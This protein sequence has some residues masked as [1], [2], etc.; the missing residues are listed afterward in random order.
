MS[1]PAQLWQPRGQDAL[2]LLC[3]HSCLIAPGHRGQCGVRENIH[4]RLVTLTYD[5]I[6]ALNLD[7]IEKKPLFHFLPGTTTLSL[8][9]PGCNLGCSFCQ[10]ASLSQPPR[11]GMAVRGEPVH[12]NRLVRMAQEAGAASIAYTYS[13][14]TIFYEL[15]LETARAACTAGLANVMVSNGFQSPQCLATL[16][17]FI[18]AANIDLKSFSDSFYHDICQARLAPVLRNLVKMKDMGWH[19]EVTTLVIPGLN[20]SER[21]LTDMARF[22]AAELGVDTPWHVSRFHPCHQM[23]DY[24]PTPLDTLR[25]AYDLGR[26][27][28]L[29]YVFVGNVPGSGLENTV[30]PGCGRTVVERRGFAVERMRLADGCCRDCGRK[31]MQSRSTGDC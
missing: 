19:L 17:P 1:T 14:P 30:C 22:I 12:P 9:T 16:K 26:S 5:R 18:Q 6:S 3:A 28:G 29:H 20:D 4:G 7:P 23:T 25:T 10:N 13:E 21:E 15:M 2:C 11:Q 31:V 24:P 27:Q 8:G